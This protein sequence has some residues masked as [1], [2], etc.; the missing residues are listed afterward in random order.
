MVCGDPGGAAA[1]APV[2][3]AIEKSGRFAVKAC[4]YRQAP[5]VFAKAG[6]EMRR[7]SE[8]TGGAEIGALLRDESPAICLL[9]T[10]VNG[11]DLEKRFVSEAR[12]AEIATLAVLDFWSNY[13]ARF[14][15]EN[16]AAAP[17]AEFLPDAIA[18]MDEVA[19]EE[20]AAAG[21]PEEK[22]AVT[23]QPAF[24]AV[25]DWPGDPGRARE[26]I[27]K[28]FAIP[29][30]ACLLLFASQ[31][32][33]E[34]GKLTGGAQNPG[35]DEVSVLALIGGNL[36]ALEARLGRPVYLWVRPHPR[37]DAAKY[38]SFAKRWP[39]VFVNGEFPG[40]DAAVGCDLLIGMNSVMLLEACLLGGNVLSVQ[41]GLRT[42]DALPLKRLGL[43]RTVYDGDGL[44]ELLAEAIRRPK[45]GPAEKERLR[46]KWG[47]A[48]G[49]VVEALA[50]L[51][52]GASAREGDYT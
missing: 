3:V 37:E 43:G 40:N 11:I 24:D 39:R 12:K 48:T 17:D 14:A 23:G 15:A 46:S 20:M 25:L 41:P 16:G 5:D 22:L 27:R 8:E 6:I 13:A 28:E 47:G 50:A 2:A 38:D 45:P 36:E 34:M 51:A 21:F 7:L 9:G 31:P 18:V 32:I 35:Y 33:S 42:R 26:K 52:K 29:G 44:C 4:G 49:R 19:A 1:V 10:S 30:E